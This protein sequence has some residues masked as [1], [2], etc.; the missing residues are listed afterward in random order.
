VDGV[1]G[2]LEPGK[3][4]SVV[5]TDGDLLEVRTHVRAVWIDGKPAD[6]DT[7]RQEHLYRRYRDRPVPAAA[8]R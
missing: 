4:A 2:S 8:P 6:L 3:S 7:G 5:L 1:L